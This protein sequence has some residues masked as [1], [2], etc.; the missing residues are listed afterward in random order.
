MANQAG[1]AALARPVHSLPRRQLARP[2]IALAALAAAAWVVTI[3]LAESMGNGPGT[4][5]LALLPF[6]GVWVVMMAAMMFPSVAPVAVLWT[7]LI[8]GAS[9]GWVRAARMS[10]FIGGYLLAWGAFGAAAFAALAG[11]GRRPGHLVPL[12]APGAAH[13]QHAD[14]VT[15]LGPFGYLMASRSSR[16]ACSQRRHASPQ[17]RQ[18]SCIRACRSHSS[19][20]P[21]QMAT[22]DSSSGLMTVASRSAWRLSTPRVAAQISVQCRHSRMHLTISVTSGSPRSASTS[23]VQA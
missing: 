22:Q 23:A 3:A 19:P 1:S 6:L 12:A 10:L 8:T 5:G 11:T 20:Q 16:Q 2:W 7:R 13:G 14:D 4:M 21:W 17:I 9:S 15:G 18:C